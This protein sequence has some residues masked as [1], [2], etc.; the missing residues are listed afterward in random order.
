MR[1]VL[2]IFL[3]GFFSQAAFGYADTK[4]SYRE[5]DGNT[6]LHLA[7]MAEKRRGYNDQRLKKTVQAL[8]QGGEDPNVTNSEEIS[9]LYL[10]A[11]YPETFKVFLT[12]AF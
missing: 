4:K 8:L 11:S 3:Y 12:S 10:S 1:S 9:P 2:L 7:I 5:E 6:K